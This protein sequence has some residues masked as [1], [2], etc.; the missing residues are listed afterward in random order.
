MAGAAMQKQDGADEVRRQKYAALLSKSKGALYMTMDRLAG[1][2]DHVSRRADNG[3]YCVVV[4]VPVN[5]V[6]RRVDKCVY[7][8]VLWCACRPSVSPCGQM[9]LLCGVPFDHVHRSV[10]KCAYCVV[11]LC[12]CRPSVS[13]C[14]QMCLRCGVG[15]CLSTMCVTVWTNVFSVWCCGVPVEPLCRR[16]DKCVYCV[17]LWCAGR[18]S[19]LLCGQ[20][21]LLCG[22]GVCL[23]TLCVAVWTNVFTV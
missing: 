9:C 23:S 20:M 5:P 3:V 6:H 11:L 4:G 17:V 12:A 14:V 15:V 8:V 1:N 19:V 10:D 22:V 7:C 18:P 16:V 21:C 13:L 2:R